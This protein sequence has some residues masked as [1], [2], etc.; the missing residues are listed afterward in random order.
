ME[1]I[2][3][4]FEDSKRLDTTTSITD[5]LRWLTPEVGVKRKA[6]RSVS[7][8]ATTGGL[9][10]FFDVATFEEFFE[11]AGLGLER[12]AAWKPE[13]TVARSDAF[14]AAVE[15]LS[16]AK[17]NLKNAVGAKKPPLHPVPPIAFIALGLAMN[18]GK[19]KYE[20]YNWRDSE[21]TVS[22]FWDAMGRHML[23]YLSGED[24]AK[25]SKVHHL[26]HVMAGAAILL[27]AELHGKL[28]DDRH[29]VNGATLE[30]M[31]KL[32]KAE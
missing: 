29:K 11:G 24:H 32:L 21:A 12:A 6:I 23:A 9:L 16:Q 27:D 31:M 15:D 17:V 19:Q 4:L 28:I 8:N 13:K 5:A 20:L 22:V 7:Y 2:F 25:D 1:F 26:A 14:K 18:D 30:Q 10:R 3:D